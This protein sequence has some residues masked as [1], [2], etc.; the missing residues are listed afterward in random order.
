MSKTPPR[1]LHP[2]HRRLL[3]LYGQAIAIAHCDEYNGFTV[4]PCEARF[5]A[6]SYVWGSTK[7]QKRIILNGH[8][9]SLGHNAHRALRYIRDAKMILNAYAVKVGKSAHTALC[10]VRVHE[11]ELL[12]WLDA[13]SINQNDVSERSDQIL[14][15]GDIFRQARF[16]SVWFGEESNLDT[17]TL[18]AF[19]NIEKFVKKANE[20]A[21]QAND[22]PTGI[23]GEYLI[24]RIS[25]IDEIRWRCVYQFF[26]NPLCCRTWILQE[27][28]LVRQRKLP[29]L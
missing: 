14:L 15:M 23:D 27:L 28:V 13:L 5:A 11:M 17:A 1:G 4:P 24:Q 26:E 9:I 2:G 6:V 18:E 10:N 8:E 12:L 21:R 29:L 3:N 22:D 16:Q 19:E 25:E 20:N 7:R